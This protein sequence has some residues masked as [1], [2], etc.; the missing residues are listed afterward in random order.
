MSGIRKIC[1]KCGKEFDCYHNSSCWCLKYKLSKENISFLKN[2]Y[3]DCLCE[4]CLR[5]YSIR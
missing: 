1:P 3:D 4:D 5:E 2:T